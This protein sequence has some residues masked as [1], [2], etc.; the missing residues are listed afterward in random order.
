MNEKG[1]APIVLILALIIF[2]LIAGGV[3]FL[4]NNNKSNNLSQQTITSTSPSTKPQSVT[5]TTPP[6]NAN[7]ELFSIDPLSNGPMLQACGKGLSEFPATA[8][9]SLKT[10]KYVDLSNNKLS[11]LP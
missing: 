9:A 10:S 6:S 3:Y 2:G 1:F 11:S 8:N 5:S 4:V 7:Q